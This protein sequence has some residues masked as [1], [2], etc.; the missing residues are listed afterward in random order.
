VN[1]AGVGSVLPA[2]SVARTEKVWLPSVRDDAL[3]GL[4]HDPNAPPSTRHW[5]VADSVA[6]KLN[7]GD[8]VLLGSA[9]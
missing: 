3:Y 6:E 5:N 7:D 9:G 4:E 8:W 1:E 2:A